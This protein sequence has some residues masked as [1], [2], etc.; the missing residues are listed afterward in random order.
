MVEVALP[1]V[2]STTPMS[3]RGP[4]DPYFRADEL[5]RLQVL[6]DAEHGGTVLLRGPR[7]VGK[8][9]LADELT[10]R[11]KREAGV[12]VLEGRALGAGGASFHPFAEIVRQAMAWAE[13]VG[14]TEAL[15][16]PILFDLEPVLRHEGAED[17]GAS[18]PSLDQKLRFFEGVRRLLTG[19][20]ERARALIVV[21]EL[22]RADSD[23]L[24]LALHLAEHLFGDRALEPDLRRPGLLALVVRDD[25]TISERARDFLA[26]TAE[27]RT[28]ETLR[29][30]GLDLD[31]LRR[32]V[33][34][35]HVLQRLLEASDGLPSELDELI[36]ALPGNVEELFQRKLE[37][38]TAAERTLLEALATYGQPASPRLLAAAIEHP[39]PAVAKMLSEL[40]TRRI[41]DR[42]IAGGEISFGFARRSNLEV[43]LRATPSE[44]LA[45]QHSGWARAL[46]GAGGRGGVAQ[47]AHHQLRSTEPAR[48][49]P[50][51]IRAAETHAVAGAFD[52]AAQILEEARP[53]AKGD[54]AVAI[55]ERLSELASLRAEPRAAQRYLELWKAAVPE[56]EQGR[57]LL[58]EAELLN[59][60]GEYARALEVVEAARSRLASAAV[61]PR[62]SLELAAAEASYQLGQHADAIRAGRA[63]LAL[64]DADEVGAPATLRTSLLNL[65]GKIALATDDVSGA[66]ERFA[67]MFALATARGLGGETA[68]AHVNLGL[69]H[70][71]EGD[72]DEAERHLEIAIVE[73]RGLNALEPLAFANLNLGVLAH[74]KG[75][76]GRAIDHYRE[77]R[78]L[79]GRLG[80]RTQLARVLHNLGNLYLIAGDL[81]RA[82]AHNDEALRTARALGV[83]RLIALASGLDGVLRAESGDAEG[84]EIALREAMVHQRRLGAE[85]PLETLVELASI[86][87]R[88]GELERAE[89]TLAEVQAA[90]PEGGPRQLTAR[91]KLVAG[92]VADARGAPEAEALLRAAR[93]EIEALGE[94]LLLRDAELALGG[95]LAGRGQ[96]AMARIHL[97]AARAVQRAVAEE[98]PLE[99]REG[100]LS[101]RAQ[102]AVEAA[103]GRLET[104]G[105]PV[106]PAAVAAPVFEPSGPEPE[107][108]VVERSPE[109]TQRYGAIIGTSPKLSRVFRILDRV[110]RSDSTVLIA[111]ESGTGKELIAEAIHRNSP[112]ASGPFVKLNCAALVESLL[113]SELF[114]HERGSFTGAHQRKTGRFEMA[115]GGTIFLDEIGDIS[116]KTQVALLR[117]LQEFEFERV[118]G[119]RPIKLEA[120]VVCATN[121][122]LAQMVR[123]GTFREDLYYRLKGVTVE[124]PPLRERSE[125]IPALAEHFLEKYAE[126]SASERRLLSPAARE[127]LVRYRWPGNIRELENVIR[128]VALFADEAEIQRRDLEEYRELF[129]DSPSIVAALGDSR[130]ATPSL[131]PP[132]PVASVEPAERTV[133]ATPPPF[134]APP[135]RAVTPPPAP[136]EPVEAA[137]PEAVL[138]EAIFE[139][140]VP[141]AE[142]KRRIQDEA[143]ARALRS[144][145]GNITKAAEMLGMKRPR[146]SQ[147][148]NASEE[149]KELCQGVGR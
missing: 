143:I 95:W 105:R 52:A 81:R 74:Q 13:Q 16:D 138:I 137:A 71:R 146:L 73:A 46:A 78:S 103:I 141:L 102:A 50:L 142:L 24:D 43:T 114:G 58:R 96:R 33:Q 104:A 65:L 125:D 132:P 53:H 84:A 26:T 6:L 120:R 5:A 8:E 12:V 61:G 2:P 111:G 27:R 94:R 113:L 121:R 108:V 91:L 136:A 147:I 83:E 30:V 20:L 57:V 21:R 124:V 82:R 22:E 130:S 90:L 133:A 54:L 64:L 76:L 10:R 11:A 129:E 100:F 63:G 32:Y 69:A 60:T 106:T 123:D 34:S 7:G 127:T 79:F 80:N 15:I 4:T 117:V 122:N 140:G 1:R 25:G 131:P 119:G 86:Q 45:R 19:V 37:Q 139:Q 88:A 67:E 56:A 89:A 128:S 55:L 51:A 44:G 62:V 31:G 66:R 110:A 48:G 47:L 39:V 59:G 35:D 3:G 85:R 68:R 135:V 70:L 98:L 28:V 40:R 36:D 17:P 29:L 92:R 134:V 97:A 42:H 107:A 118:G 115:A 77:C 112:R 9:H 87:L 116:A 145:K 18:R 38:L 99:L 93:D 126:E 75:E 72:V 14:A 101:A 49:V 149:L 144:A 23:T 109:W 41:L 148:I